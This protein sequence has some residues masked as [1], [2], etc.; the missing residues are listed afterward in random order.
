MASLLRWLV[1]VG[2]KGAAETLVE[3]RRRKR[4]LP[5]SRGELCETVVAMQLTLLAL[6]LLGM[7]TPLL[8]QE[9]SRLEAP[10]TNRD[11]SSSAIITQPCSELLGRR[12]RD[13]YSICTNSAGQ[14]DVLQCRN[15]VWSWE[16]GEEP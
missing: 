10:W 13:G 7:H 11:A 2:L 15:S 5:R 4:S 9:A 6:A 16:E 8:A 14:L 3:P 1:G 12:C